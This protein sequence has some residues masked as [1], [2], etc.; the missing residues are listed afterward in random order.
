VAKPRA[1]QRKANGASTN[2]WLMLIFALVVLSLYFLFNF[3]RPAGHRKNFSS[4]DPHQMNQ[5]VV[6]Q[7]E[8]A[9]QQPDGRAMMYYRRR[10]EEHKQEVGL[11]LNSERIQAEYEN[12]RA[13]IGTKSEL[14]LPKSA[15]GA[16]SMGNPPDTANWDSSA[17]P[18]SADPSYQNPDMQVQAALQAQKIQAEENK[19]AREQYVRELIARGHAAGYRVHVDKNNNVEWQEEEGDRMPQ[20][21]GPATLTPTYEA[22]TKQKPPLKSAEKVPPAKAPV[23]HR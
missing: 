8:P 17:L 18:T 3:S 4:V 5:S 22:L 1:S 23:Q 13:A 11:K 12:R 21:M 2:Q 15:V 14:G 19:F 6:D 16:N 10:A 9:I 7:V 20:S